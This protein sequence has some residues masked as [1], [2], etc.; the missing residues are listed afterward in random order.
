MRNSDAGMSIP[1]IQF[2]EK[3]RTLTLFDIQGP[4]PS[5]HK[6]GGPEIGRWRNSHELSGCER[7]LY[8]NAAH[9]EK[10]AWR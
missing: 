2:N 4:H 1:Q 10:L 7:L 6:A 9:S 8:P 5:A 3:R